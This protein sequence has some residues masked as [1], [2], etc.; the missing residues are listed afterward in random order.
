MRQR[1]SPDGRLMASRPPNVL[2]TGTP[3]TGKTT[4]CQLIAEQTGLRHVNVGERVK[5]DELHS[6][7]D[8]EYEC[9]TLDE[10]KVCCGDAC[11]ALS[12][13]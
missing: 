2:V 5:Q 7:W 10:D 13:S 8:P 11:L 1:S 3:G 9:Y 12:A 6:G 4:T